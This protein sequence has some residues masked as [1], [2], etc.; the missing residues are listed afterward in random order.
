[1]RK[2]LSIAS[3]TL[4]FIGLNAHG[5]EKQND[6][7]IKET[8]NWLKEYGFNKITNLNDVYG[9]P[10]N[11]YLNE[12]EEYIDYLYEE[13]GMNYLIRVRLEKGNTNQIRVYSSGG[14]YKIWIY[15]IQTLNEENP[16]GDGFIWGKGDPIFG[17]LKFSTNKEYA[18]KVFKA[19]EHLFYLLEWKVEC[20]NDLVDENKF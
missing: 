6:A 4:L 7:T 1:M 10:S 9:K 20:I 11:L 19:F 13:T 12:D 14:V 3:I 18:L 5:Q 2:L 15:G 17:V 8:I 16:S